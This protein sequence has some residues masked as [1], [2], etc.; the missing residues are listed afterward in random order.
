MQM[1]VKQMLYYKEWQRL[2]YTRCVQD[3]HASDGCDDLEQPL[4]ILRSRTNFY[5]RT[6]VLEIISNKW[7]K[8]KRV[9]R[10]L[11]VKNDT[12]K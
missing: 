3:D 8:D 2:E 7:D 5:Q 10:N 4:Q 12:N 9:Q 6:V 1:E 11:K